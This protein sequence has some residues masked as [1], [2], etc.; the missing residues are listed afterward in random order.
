[1]TNPFENENSN[2]VVLINDEGQYSLWPAFLDVPSGWDK[3][4]GEESRTVCLDYINLHWD[5]MR[6]NSLKNIKNTKKEN[7]NEYKT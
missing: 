2:Y 5:D 7:K 4:T 1:M 6:P 3:E